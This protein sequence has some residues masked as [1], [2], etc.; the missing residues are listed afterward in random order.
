MQ[1]LSISLLMVCFLAVSSFGQGFEEDRR[2]ETIFSN[3]SVK[4]T[5]IWGG[6]TT[7]LNYL[8]SKGALHLD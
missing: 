3:S 6:N 5:G 4:L 8:L 2:D 7:N 1:R